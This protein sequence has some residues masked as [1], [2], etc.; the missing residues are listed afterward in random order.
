MP[1]IEKILQLNLEGFKPGEIA[2][3]INEDAEEGVDEITHQAVSKII[4]ENA[5][6]VEVTLVGKM[7]TFTASEYE[8]YSLANGRTRYGGEKGVKVNATIEE[9]RAYI[10]SGWTP[11]MLLEKWQMTKEEL[12]Q[13]TW[14]LAKAELRDKKPTIN[15][16][17]DFFRF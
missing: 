15:Y 13:L 14:R 5:P 6:K 16:E 12:K 11:N 17:R 10:N 1:N 9:L 2:K 3:K 4:K 8:E 7:Q